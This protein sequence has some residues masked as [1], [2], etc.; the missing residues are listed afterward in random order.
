MQTLR[1]LSEARFSGV[2]LVIG[3]FDG[4]HRGHQAL[5]RAGRHRADAAGTKLVV[6][7]FDPHPSAILAP[8]RVPPT[9]TPLPEKERLIAEHG[10]D[11]LVVVRSDPGFFA[12]AAEDFIT[13]IIM[14]RFA[15]VAMVEGHSFRFGHRRGGDVDTLRAAGARLGFEVEVVE[16]IRIALGGH[17]DAIISSSLVRNLLDSGSVDQAAQCLGRSYALI[18]MVARGQERGRTIGFPT[19]NLA[20]AGQLVPAEGVYAGRAITA[21]GT[22]AA[23]ISIGRNL[24]FGQAPRTVEAHLLDFSGDLYD[25]PIRLEFLD[26]LR[27]HERFESAGALREQIQRDVAATRSAIQ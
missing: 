1:D 15:P 13:D 4:V 14:E 17:P 6:M 22:H 21:A 11:V 24:T 26:W 3:N 7:T 20:V 2:L 9:L 16:P 8:D 12:L 5:L 27:S 25:R 10:A 18:G 19:A 23:A